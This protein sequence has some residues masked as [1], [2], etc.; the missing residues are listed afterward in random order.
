VLAALPLAGGKP[1]ADPFFRTAE[2]VGLLELRAAQLNGVGERP[3]Q[4][5]RSLMR[6]RLSA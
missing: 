6:L 2:L 1:I 3:A 4:R 5:L